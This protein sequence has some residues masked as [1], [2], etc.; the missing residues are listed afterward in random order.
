[1]ASEGSSDRNWKYFHIGLREHDESWLDGVSSKSM[2][3]GVGKGETPSMISD[4]DDEDENVRGMDC[5]K[6]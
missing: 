2:G 5:V 6:F 3:D 1:M 4:D